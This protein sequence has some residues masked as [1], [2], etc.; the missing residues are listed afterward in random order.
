MNSGSDEAVPP[1]P[2]SPEFDPLSYDVLDHVARYRMGVVEALLRLPSCA[3]FSPKGLRR[4]LRDL[5]GAGGLLGSAPLYGDLRYFYLT[6]AG[7]QALGNDPAGQGAARRHGPLSEVA[8]VRAYGLVAFCCLADRARQRL[9]A[10]EFRQH[11]PAHHRPGLPM[12]YYADHGAGTLGFAR[13]DAGGQGR[14][15]RLVDRV[16]DDIERHRAIPAFR[17]SIDSGTF[18][19]AVVTATE[20]KAERL[21]EP[22]GECSRASGVPVLVH[23][24]PDLIQLVAPPPRG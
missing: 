2:A 12:G 23:V 19:L 20:R 11:F 4:R 3:G 14:W 8:K 10:A 17:A 13:V 22:L 24:V 5:G 16:R 9:T 18:E 21:R 6:A 15:E 7:E 1:S